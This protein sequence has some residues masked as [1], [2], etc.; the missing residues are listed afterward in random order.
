VYGGSH[1]F[2][3]TGK[4]KFI[5]NYYVV[6][7]ASPTSATVYVDNT[8]Y[9]LA[10]DI[11][12]AGQGILAECEV[13]LVVLYLFCSRCVG[14]YIVEIASGSACRSYYFQ[15]INSAGTTSR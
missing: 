7:G 11:G 12:A 8:A 4:I 14:T 9:A 3:N 5:A 2:Q 10:L 13:S 15:F 1:I 6:A